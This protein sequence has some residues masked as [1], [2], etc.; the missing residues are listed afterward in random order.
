MKIDFL[1]LFICFL[2]MV[3]L[4]LPWVIRGYDSY[5]AMNPETRQGELR[6]HKK[7][8]LSPMG[9]KLYEDGVLVETL[10]FVS[11]GISLAGLMLA[12]AAAL[13]AI[14]FRIRWVRLSLFIIAVLGVLIF[15]MSLG[16]GLGIGLKSSF[17][18]GLPVSLLGITLIFASSI[19][20]LAKSAPKPRPSSVS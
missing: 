13:S 16:T 7:I 18:W 6:F 15:F 3:G 5:A 17:G 1:G 9:V 8:L 2:I 14:R 19:N 10:W 4:F 20:E 11:P 12:S